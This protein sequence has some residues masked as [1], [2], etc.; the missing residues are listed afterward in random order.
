MHVN[1]V[2]VGGGGIGMHAYI[3]YKYIKSY[4]IWLS[5]ICVNLYLYIY[6][7]ACN[8]QDNITFKELDNNVTSWNDDFGDMTSIFN[9]YSSKWID[10]NGNYDVVVKWFSPLQ[11]IMQSLVL[12]DILLR[13]F[14]SYQI[15]RR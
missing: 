6:M 2:E 12:L 5:K 13:I 15:A 3:K 7:F 11:G 9:S 8:H 14:H 1:A 10:F 4:W